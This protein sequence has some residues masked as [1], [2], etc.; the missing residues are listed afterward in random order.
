MATD[1]VNLN[2]RRILF[3]AKN[4]AYTNRNFFHW[5]ETR[6]DKPVDFPCVTQANI[7][8]VM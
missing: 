7:K 6:G 2:G 8:Q 5:P 3:A 1:K 4:V